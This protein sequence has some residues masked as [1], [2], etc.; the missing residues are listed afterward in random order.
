MNISARAISEEIL[1]VQFFPPRS[2]VQLI[3]EARLMGAILADAVQ[4]YLDDTAAGG[5]R[6]VLADVEEWLASE[7]TTS[8]FSF[9]NVCDALGLDHLAARDALRRRRPVSRP[10][11]P[12]RVVSGRLARP[13][14]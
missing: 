14:R 8:P 5:R 12:R 10:R 2:G 3:P 11:S 13:P 1:P 9:R 7:D 4:V 6:R